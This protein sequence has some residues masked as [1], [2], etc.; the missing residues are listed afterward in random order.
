[1][2]AFDPMESI[3]AIRHEFGEHGG[4]NMSVEVSTTFTVMH[5]STMPDIFH[6]LLGP[7]NAGCYLYGR[8]YNPTVYAL[9]RQLAA[10]ESTEAAYCTASGMSA[11][12]TTIF[13]LCRAGEHVVASDTLYGGTYALL[14][15][16]L[17]ERSGERT[18]FVNIRDLDAVKRAFTPQTRVLYVETVANPTLVVADLPA[19]AAIAHEHGAALVVDNTFSPLIVTPAH[20][21][22]DVVVH[23]L[24][25]FVSG[26]SDIIAGVVCGSKEFISSMMDV[27]TGALMLLGPTMDPRIAFELSTRL[28]HLG[29]R[30]REHSRRAAAMA[31]LCERRGLRVHYPG[32][33][34]HPDHDRLDA[35]RNEG[36]GRGGL[37]AI[38]LETEERADRFMEYLQNKMQFGFIAVSLGFTD[39][40]MSVSASST[41]SEMTPEDLARAGISPGLVRISAGITGTLEQ[42]LDQLDEAIRATLQ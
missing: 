24:T 11:I 27:T 41:S 13:Q 35:L 9:A 31:E 38:D 42:R 36:Y 33:P 1:M 2:S 21:G 7:D 10:L 25:K 16:F 5:A 12:A 23:S 8:H 26:S 40:L 29:V 4:V 18:T 34:S 30:V 6:G 37:F 3:A 28:P 39:T 32:L 22:A 15:N 19:L 14:R 20:H 17:P